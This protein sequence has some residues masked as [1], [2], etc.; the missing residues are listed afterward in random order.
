MKQPFVKI[1]YRASTADDYTNRVNTDERG[2]LL[3]KYAL[4]YR[5]SK[6]A[7]S[8]LVLKANIKQQMKEIEAYLEV[9]VTDNKS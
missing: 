9:N 3:K 2:R 6:K 4:A 8:S 1:S 5:K 7:D